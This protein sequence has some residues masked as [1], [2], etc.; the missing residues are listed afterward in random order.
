MGPVL[1]LFDAAFLINADRDKARLDEAVL[2]LARVGIEAE[3]FAA[4]TNARGNGNV[5]PEE[6]GLTQ[7][8]SAVIET[9]RQRGYTSVLILEDDVIFRDDFHDR[10]ASIFSRIQPLTYDLLYF[11]DWHGTE[12]NGDPRLVNISGTLCTHAYAVSSRYYATYLLALQNYQQLGAVD[13]I[14]LRL[15]AEKWAIVPNL[16]GQRGGTSTVYN[17]ARSLRWSAVDG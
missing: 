3:R 12:Q 2:E 10:W 9:A 4:I 11:Y 14:L 6:L 1:D 13:Q 8:H 17:C 15:P 5:R 7:S 16:V